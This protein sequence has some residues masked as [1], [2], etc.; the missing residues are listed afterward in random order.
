MK[1]M[2]T[3]RKTQSSFLS[4][5]CIRVNI[6]SRFVKTASWPIRDLRQ[7]VELMSLDSKAVL[8]AVVRFPIRSNRPRSLISC[9]N[10]CDWFVFTFL[11]IHLRSHF[12]LWDV[13]ARV[14]TQLLS[15]SLGCFDL[16]IVDVDLLE[17]FFII[18][19]VNLGQSFTFAYDR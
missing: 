10:F 7:V 9:D 3:W 16:S 12:T 2:N 6:V 5:L 11:N 4:D 19:I 17:V 8:L 15:G 18:V 1:G 13:V 14:I